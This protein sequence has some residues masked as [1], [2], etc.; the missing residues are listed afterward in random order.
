[1]SVVAAK[2][3]DD[4]RSLFTMDFVFSYSFGISLSMK[5]FLLGSSYLEFNFCKRARKPDLSTVYIGKLS[6]QINWAT[7]SFS[8]V[9][10]VELGEYFLLPSITA[11]SVGC[12]ELAE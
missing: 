4:M 3:D 9:A 6:L 12:F 10:S 7:A 5:K 8:L 1:M 2:N 11:C